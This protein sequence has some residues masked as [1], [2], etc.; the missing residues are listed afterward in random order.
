LHERKIESQRRNSLPLE[1]VGQGLHV[2]VLHA[3]PGAVRQHQSR[4]RA[5]WTLPD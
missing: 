3:G 2:A 4:D 5:E 1:G